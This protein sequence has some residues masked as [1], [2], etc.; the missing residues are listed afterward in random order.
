MTLENESVEEE[1]SWPEGRFW[2]INFEIL[3]ELDEKYWRKDVE[4]ERRNKSEW[5]V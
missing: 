1:H 5:K 3:Q 2:N 4:I